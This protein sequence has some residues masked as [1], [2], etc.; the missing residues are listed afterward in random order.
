[1]IKRKSDKTL[2]KRKHSSFNLKSTFQ[3]ISKSIK[4][5]FSKIT[6]RHKNSI[7][8]KIRNSNKIDKD[9]INDISNNINSIKSTAKV[10]KEGKLQVEGTSVKRK[11]LISMIGL[12]IVSMI[13]TS[14]IMYINSSKTISSQS[15]ENMEG[16]TT[17]SIQTISVMM[18]KVTNE[19]FALSNSK[20]NLNVLLNYAQ[21]KNSKDVKNI[22]EGFKSYISANK[23]VD[24]ISLVSPEGD[25]VADSEES[26]VGANEVDNS[27]HSTSSSGG[28][29]ISNTIKSVAGDKGV[30]VFTYP[31]LDEANYSKCVG[32]IALHVYA[33]SFSTYIENIKIGQIEDSYAYLIDE[34]GNIIYHPNKEKIGQTIDI[35]EIKDVVDKAMKGSNVEV[36][37]VEYKIN[38]NKV[39]SSY[40]LVPRTNW[41]MVIDANSNEIR[42][43]VITMVKQIALVAL[44][45]VI[46]GSIIIM[47][48]ANVIINPI[49]T[50]A[51]LVNK[52]AKLD[53]TNDNLAIIKSKDEIGLIYRSIINMR[54]VLR[55]VV[56][57]I[58]VTTE[59]LTNNA[60]IV[61][62][63][64][65]SLKI[66]ADETLFETESVSSGIEET[67][68]TSQEIA[69]SS[70]EMIK[71]VQNIA[72]EALEGYEITKDILK[73]AQ[74]IKASAIESKEKSNDIYNSVKS[75]LEVAITSSKEVKQID[76]LADSILKIT[77]QTNLLALNAAIEA[78]RAGEA[79]RGFSVVA[80]EV[81]K[82]AEES[83][84]T[85]ADIQ[86][87]VKIVNKSVEELALSAGRMSNFIEQQVINDYDKNIEQG[88][89]YEK[90][91]DQFNNFMNE[92]SSEAAVLNQ[93][94]EGIVTAIDEV[95]VTVTE[96]A[97]GVSS[98]SS[99]TMDIVGN[100]E[101]IKNTAIENKENA[102]KL[103][104]TTLKFRL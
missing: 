52:T 77:Q 7:S 62:E 18:D 60:N 49:V 27:Y 38:G 61:E 68:A 11:I 87:I 44:A 45:I 47:V 81:R 3:N 73:R 85:A 103:N 63:S 97:M 93:A 37:S 33:E 98:I 17:S 8:K 10:Y 82:L 24:R 95:S 50:V 84:K 15:T 46:I 75:E 99:K 64:T 54:E 89:L 67:S 19:A 12:T 9:K 6:I 74:G 20:D 66:K 31:V 28:K 104:D 88:A 41:T 25:I 100:I 13:I 69:A 72:S 2:K 43:P 59:V 102:D 22:N 53:L 94:I 55:E 42:K 65:E 21:K 91:A 32:Y 5:A 58:A 57:D 76:K 40:G 30:L 26:L 48:M 14:T 36:G 83:G 56:G 23:H 29:W 35:P 79:G 92:F 70:T 39:M 51:A 101:S 16:I 80:D 34:K 78:A 1:M 71:S 4:N 90:D 86:R 96:G